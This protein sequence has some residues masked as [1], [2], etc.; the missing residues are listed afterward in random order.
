[1]QELSSGSF[2]DPAAYTMANASLKFSRAL[3]GWKF[4][5][6]FRSN[7]TCIDP[8]LVSTLRF[9]DVLRRGIQCSYALPVYMEIRYRVSLHEFECWEAMNLT[10]GTLTDQ[11]VDL[12]S[13]L[14]Y[15]STVSL[16]FNVFPSPSL[17]LA[18]LCFVSSD[19]TPDWILLVIKCKCFS[20]WDR[21]IILYNRSISGW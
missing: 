4:R 11:G 12:S 14:R 8:F 15:P 2:F 17:Q 10:R 20:L 18:K 21:A 1:M 6:A 7:G 9:V 16:P 13:V 19:Y 3:R 5:L